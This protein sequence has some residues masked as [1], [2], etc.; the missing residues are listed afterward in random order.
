MLLM[1]GM[2]P[3]SHIGDDYP[4]ITEYRGFSS[5]SLQ[6]VYWTFVGIFLIV[7]VI[8]LFNRKRHLLLVSLMFML[9]VVP[10]Y[11]Q[12]GYQYLNATLDISIPVKSKVHLINRYSNKVGRARHSSICEVK[13][14][15]YPTSKHRF[16]CGRGELSSKLSSQKILGKFIWI[17][18]KDGYFGRRWVSDVTVVE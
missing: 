11:V 15:T 16:E 13:G 6:I 1:L 5:F 8:F 9:I 17:E 14:L 7:P 18:L 12:E 3:V 4:Y 10:A 2:I